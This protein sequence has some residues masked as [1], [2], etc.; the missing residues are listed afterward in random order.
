LEEV[1]KKTAVILLVAVLINGCST[2]ARMFPDNST[3][4]QQAEALPELEIPPDLSG[5][6]INNEMYILDED[7]RSYSAQPIEELPPELPGI[8]SVNAEE[9]DEDEEELE[10]EGGDEADTVDETDAADETD[11][12][13]E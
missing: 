11:T 13:D 8:P 12:A 5:G 1:M 7:D 6:G 10:A 2:V 9:V 3:D 4:Y